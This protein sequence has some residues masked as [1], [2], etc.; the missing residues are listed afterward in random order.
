[1]RVTIDATGVDVSAWVDALRRESRGDDIRVFNS[2]SV[3][4]VF[5][6][7]GLDFA[8]RGTDVFHASPLTLRP[9]HRSKLT[10]TIEDLSSWLM[11]ELHSPANIKTARLFA[12]NGLEPAHGLIAVSEPARQ[13][14]I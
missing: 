5:G 13:D 14:G 8:I 7:A 10:A 9:P 12:E 2:S 11:P 4:R 1:M 3:S 6:S